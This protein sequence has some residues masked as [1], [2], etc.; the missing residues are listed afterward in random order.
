MSGLWAV[1]PFVGAIRLSTVFAYVA[2]V[3]AVT[4]HRRS[5]LVGIIAGMAWVSAFEIV[6][7]AFGT[8]FGKYDAT[9]LFYLTFTISGWVVAGYV[10]GIRPHPAL[11][12]VWLLVFLG[13]MAYGFHPNHYGDPNFSVGQ[14]IFNVVTKD[15]LAAIYLLGGL[16]PFRLRS[17]R[18][19]PASE[20]I[21]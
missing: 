14:E 7:Q 6:F 8:V 16:R 9:H 19:T 18:A 20:P 11:L 3:V 10:A 1:F 5:L 21:Q 15:G 17:R 4:W 2:V 13:W 12:L